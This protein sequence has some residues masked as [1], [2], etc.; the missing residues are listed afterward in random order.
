MAGEKYI[1]AA[2]D[3]SVQITV[4]NILNPEGYIF[5]EKCS[6][7]VSLLRLVR[8]LHPDFIV[9]DIGMQ[10]TEAR[11]ALEII[12][13]E[14]LCAGILLGKYKD[15]VIF[16][17]LEKSNA[18][19]CCPK[20]VNRDVLLNT[21]E[22]AILNFNRVSGFDRKI[23]EMTSNYE[24]MQLIERAKSMLMERDGLSEKDA[25]DFI[26]K[27]SMDCRMSMKSVAGDIVLSIKQAK[28]QHKSGTREQS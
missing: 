22:M 7:A 1:V 23:K 8:S 2:A 24:S 3:N 14:M 25:Y 4:R 13:S 18:F 27:R 21:V 17:M 12:G 15:S 5:M 11:H 16:S 19:S 6:D 28:E 9:A 10:Q 20:P 26:R